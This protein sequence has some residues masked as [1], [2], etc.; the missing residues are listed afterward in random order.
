MRGQATQPTHLYGDTSK[1]FKK[2]F[3]FL[4]SRIF[5]DANIRGY[6]YL[7]IIVIVRNIHNYLRIREYPLFAA[8]IRERS[9][10][11]ISSWG[12]N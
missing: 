8:G 7:Q 5:A 9:E 12:S 6:S 11:L 2:M 10:N 1:L 4:Y 3:K